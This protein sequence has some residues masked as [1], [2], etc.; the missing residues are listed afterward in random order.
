MHAGRTLSKALDSATLFSVTGLR[1]GAF[2]S[3]GATFRRVQRANILVVESDDHIREAIAASLTLLGAEVR[4]A[5]DPH[6][7]LDGLFSGR[8]LPDAVLVDMGTPCQAMRQLLH[9]L[10]ADPRLAH[11][12]VLT[13]G[14]ETLAPAPVHATPQPF[15]V[16]ELAHILVSLCQGDRVREASEA[17]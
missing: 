3:Q 13:I 6:E 15:D 11:I 17:T 8:T 14:A 12:P 2:A 7:G 5:A 10:Q 9:L 1:E 16:E 4:Q